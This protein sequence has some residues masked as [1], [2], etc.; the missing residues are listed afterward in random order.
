M[1]ALASAAPALGYVGFKNWVHTRRGACA[2]YS[3]STPRR[4]P[5]RGHRGRCARPA[6]HRGDDRPRHPLARRGARRRARPGRHRLAVD[7]PGRG[8][9]RGAAAATRAGLESDRRE[10]PCV[11]AEAARRS[12]SSRSS[13]PPTLEAAV[14]GRVDRHAGDPREGPVPAGVDARPRRAPERGRRDPAGRTPSSTRTSSSACRAS[15]STTCPNV[16]RVA[17]VHRPVRRRAGAGRACV[18]SATSSPRAARARPTATCPSSRRWGWACPTSPS[19]LMVLERARAQGIGRALPHPVRAM[20][21]LQ[22]PWPRRTH[23]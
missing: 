15:S 10:A 18:R 1:H 3:C 11:R 13:R 22:P 2:I 20:P 6:A 17:R 16:K 8:D 14:P 9:Q 4:Q 23:D 12:S 21:H 19:A 7:D 5:A